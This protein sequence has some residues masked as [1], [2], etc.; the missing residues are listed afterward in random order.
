LSDSREA[1]RFSMEDRAMSPRAGLG[2][3]HIAR[4]HG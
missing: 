4:L 2:A 1:L 3:I